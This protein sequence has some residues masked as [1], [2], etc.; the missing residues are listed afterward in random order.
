[1][2]V[3]GGGGRGEGTVS[4][5]RQLWAGLWEKRSSEEE[6]DCVF[7]VIHQC[8]FGVIHQCNF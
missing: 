3:G 7:G 6:E 2:G 1:M 8:V 5:K 4:V